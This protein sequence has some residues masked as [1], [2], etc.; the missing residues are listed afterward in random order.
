MKKIIEFL[1]DAL[2]NNNAPS[3]TRLNV[4]L[5]VLQWSVAISIGFYTVLIHFKDLII[6]YLGIVIGGLL[7]VMGVKAFE[8]VKTPGGE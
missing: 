7:G 3:S 2:S 1:K 5:V 4:L 8:K 6:P